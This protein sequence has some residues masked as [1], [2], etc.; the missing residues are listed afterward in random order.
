M[1]YRR[2]DSNGDYVFGG[3]ANDFLSGT[4]AVAQAIRTRLRLLKNEW[5][6]D[7][8]GGLPLFDKILGYNSQESA[9]K[10]IIDR[11]LGTTGVTSIVTSDFSYDA[12]TRTITIEAIVDTEYGNTS[13]SYTM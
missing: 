8:E 7:L 13:F 11:I 2:L 6:E 3:N 4:I 9:K 5:W 12:D 1:M 10:Q